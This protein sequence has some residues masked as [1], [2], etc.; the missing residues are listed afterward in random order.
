MLGRW[1][2]APVTGTVIG[3]SGKSHQIQGFSFISLCSISWNNSLFSSRQIDA[4][5]PLC[6][7][8]AFLSW[9]TI[10]LSRYVKTALHLPWK[11]SL[12]SGPKTWCTSLQERL[13]L[14]WITKLRSIYL[15]STRHKYFKPNPPIL[16]KYLSKFN[17]YNTC[18]KCKKHS[19]GYA[20]L[21]FW[22][23]SYLTAVRILT[24]RQYYFLFIA[25]KMFR[26]SSW[27]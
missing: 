15:C 1:W 12:L 13:R 19:T 21:S 26:I 18:W 16:T 3:M 20:D 24:H 2:P 27:D 4:L 14:Q 22:G 9:H 11:R 25:S 5:P 17:I 6:F 23:C 10:L 8:S 7:S